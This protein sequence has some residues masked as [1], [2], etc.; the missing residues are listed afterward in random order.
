MR[1]ESSGWW[2]D[3]RCCSS[4]SCKR[5]FDV[6][7]KEN[8]KPN[9]RARLTA[10]DESLKIGAASWQSF[11]MAQ[12]IVVE[13]MPLVMEAIPEPAV[14]ST[15]APCWQAME[16]LDAAALSAGAVD[17]VL[18]LDLDQGEPSAPRLLDALRVAQAALR[19]ERERACSAE[20]ALRSERTC[21]SSAKAECK[22]AQAQRDATVV[23]T[24]KSLFIQ[25]EKRSARVVCEATGLTVAEL[26]PILAHADCCLYHGPEVFNL[27]SGEE[28]HFQRL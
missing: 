2:A 11:N 17:A 22:R 4:R 27:G 3:G 20:A 24:V 5:H 1:T 19:K 15:P 7:G 6:L 18:G 26:R 16:Q 14:E 23:A 8:K 13:A 9:K 28:A 25:V 12:C 10:I 21:A